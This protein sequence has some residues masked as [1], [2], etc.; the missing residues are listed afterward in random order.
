MSKRDRSLGTAHSKAKRYRGHAPGLTWQKSK[1]RVTV[2][3]LSV[4]DSAPVEDHTVPNRAQGIPTELLETAT[5]PISIRPTLAQ[6]APGPTE[7]QRWPNLDSETPPKPKPAKARAVT[8]R[9]LSFD[10][11]TYI[12]VELVADFAGSPDPIEPPGVRDADLLHSA[13]GRQTAAFGGRSKYSTLE[14]IAASLFFGICQNHAFHNG[15]KR[16]AVVALLCF[17]DR[18]G[19]HLQTNQDDLY[20]LVTKLASHALVPN[21]SPDAD[22]DNVKGW[23]RKRLR[24]IARGELPLRFRDFRSILVAL[25][26]SLDSPAAG[27]VTLRRTSHG[28]QLRIKIPHHGET[29]ELD[30]GYIAKAR[31]ALHLDE[32][33]GCDSASFYGTAIRPDEFISKY[34]ILLRRLANV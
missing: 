5:Q 1:V 22:V 28:H 4:I 9:A 29:K 20:K 23:I 17:L 33:H 19:Y 2:A 24:P 26:G 3:T 7:T 14:G 11:L 32:A 10:D 27:Y 6:R 15:N 12:H 8:L 31:K 21:G 34:R 16:T 30:P 25:G 18:N 13:I